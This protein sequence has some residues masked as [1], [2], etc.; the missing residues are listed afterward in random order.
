MLWMPLWL[1]VLVGVPLLFLGDGLKIGWASLIGLFL[2]FSLL[3]GGV[4]YAVFA[5][6]VTRWIRGRTHA[7][8]MKAAWLL[9]LIFAPFCMICLGIYALA[10]SEFF[11]WERIID[12]LGMM[13][14][15][16]LAFGYAYVLIAQTAFFFLQKS[17]KIV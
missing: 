11:R 9:P 8:V 5:F 4:P 10:A 15:F 6:G 1:P 2:G 13:G 14:A 3:Y 7:Q 12:T 16:S 17:G